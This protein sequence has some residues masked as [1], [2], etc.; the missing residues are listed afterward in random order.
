MG[1]PEFA[2]R[3][4]GARY[5]FTSERN[6]HLFQADPDRY[7][8]AY[9]GW[10]AYAMARSGDRV[11]VDPEAFK[12]MDGRLLLFYRSGWNNTLKKWDRE[13]DRLLEKADTNWETQKQ[14]TP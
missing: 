1:S 14:N 10:C 3:Y 8:P 4:E 11:E 5:L 7:L 13:P 12:I 2:T 9:G 6:L